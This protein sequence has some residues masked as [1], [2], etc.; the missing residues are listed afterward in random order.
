MDL[1]PGNGPRAPVGR[2]LQ[3][4]GGPDQGEPQGH[5]R[6]P[7]RCLGKKT[8]GCRKKLIKYCIWMVEMI[9][10]RTIFLNLYI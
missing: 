9:F 5:R 3:G 2:G 1:S 10:C 8:D 4:G 7:N 6:H